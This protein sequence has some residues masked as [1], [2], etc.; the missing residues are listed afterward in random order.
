MTT[1]FVTSNISIQQLLDRFYQAFSGFSIDELRQTVTPDWQDIPPAPG[2]SLGP[3]GVAP[4][5]NMISSAFSRF[6]IDIIDILTEG[7]RVAVRATLSGIHSGVFLGIPPTGQAFTIALHEF[8][9][10]E[11]GR[12]AKTW[13]MEDWLSL[14]MQIGRFPVAPG[15]E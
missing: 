2:Q 11:N 9:Q 10:L 7:D 12:I 6:R 5:F 13:H 1:T 15:M 14:F 3:D 8:H 4:V